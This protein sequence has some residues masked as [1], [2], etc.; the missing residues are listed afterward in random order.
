MKTT[1]QTIEREVFVY[2]EAKSQYIID[3][4]KPGEL[5]FEYIVKSYDY[6]DETCIRIM[7]QPV[8][9][10]IPDGI[11]ITIACIKN[12]EEKIEAV[13]QQADKDIE[14]LKERIRSLALLEYN[15]E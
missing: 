15:P 4:L 1:R 6:G 12:L 13:Q 10:T 9:I 5:P 7:E 8:L 11:D 2:A 14:D 3:H